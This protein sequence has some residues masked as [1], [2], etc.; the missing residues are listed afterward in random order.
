M[1][2]VLPA[3][4]DP[5]DVFLVRAYEPGDRNYILDS[6]LKS[7]APRRVP[8]RERHAWFQEWRPRY[9]ELLGKTPVVVA[10]D[11][12]A[13]HRILG[14]MIASR[15][16]YHHVKAWCSDYRDLIVGAMRDKLE[17]GSDAR[18]TGV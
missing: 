2:D 6:W 14:W 3:G 7:T 4:L 8:P 10:C 12:E 17:G 18:A 13:P 9:D 1:S 11:P 5:D 16:H 15:N